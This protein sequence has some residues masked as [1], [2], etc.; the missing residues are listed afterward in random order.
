MRLSRTG[1]GRHSRAHSPLPRIFLVGRRASFCLYIVGRGVIP[2]RTSPGAS[3]ESSSPPRDGAG[4]RENEKSFFGSNR[5][6][7]QSPSHLLVDPPTCDEPLPPLVQFLL[8][9]GEADGADLATVLNRGLNCIKKIVDWEVV[10]C[11]CPVATPA[12]SKGRCPPGWE[13]R[14][15][16]SRISPPGCPPQN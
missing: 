13:G 5:G 9:G 15:C 16:P 11:A 3:W 8:D 14:T 1:V 6:I 12:A 7:R 2:P 4:C 10:G